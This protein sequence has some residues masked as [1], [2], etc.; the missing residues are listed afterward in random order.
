VLDSRTIATGQLDRGPLRLRGYDYSQ[1]GAYFVTIV[2]RE[3]ACLFGEVVEDEMWLSEAGGIV[4]R[5]WLSRTISRAMVDAFI[6]M[7]NHVHGIITPLDAGKQSASQ[8]PAIDP[9][10]RPLIC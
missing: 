2:R 5:C 8:P 9:P 1:P 7:P 4:K 3:R 10:A 6:V